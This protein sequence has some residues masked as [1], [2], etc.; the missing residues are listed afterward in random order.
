MNKEEE[1]KETGINKAIMLTPVPMYDLMIF[2]L[3]RILGYHQGCRSSQVKHDLMTLIDSLGDFKRVRIRFFGD[4]P[5]DPKIPRICEGHE[6]CAVIYEEGKN[7]PLHLTDAALEKMTRDMEAMEAEN[8]RLM[9]AHDL[10]K[11]QALELVREKSEAMMRIQ[12]MEQELTDMGD[13]LSRLQASI[14]PPAPVPSPEPNP[15]P[16]PAPA[17]EPVEA[18]PSPEAVV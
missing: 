10:I 8:T 17:P 6:D 18:P 13:A 11:N 12:S 7:C 1:T 4:V 3:K 14:Q 2:H 16:P 15:E 5:D 9:E